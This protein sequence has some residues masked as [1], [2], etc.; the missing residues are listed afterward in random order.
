M[1]IG[2]SQAHDRGRLP[3]LTSGGGGRIRLAERRRMRRPPSVPGGELLL[4]AA[5]ELPEGRIGHGGGAWRLP[6]G[7]RGVRRR[8]REVIGARELDPF[9]YGGFLW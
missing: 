3:S 1:T 6:G 8:E 9:N 5:E 4:M 2:M 7:Q